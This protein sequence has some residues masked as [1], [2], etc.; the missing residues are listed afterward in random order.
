VL[1]AGC[2]DT[3]GAFD[4]FAA[5]YAETHPSS[6]DAGSDAGA[7]ATPAPDALAGRYLLAVAPAFSLDTPILFFAHFSAES[8]DSD[9]VIGLELRALSAADRQTPVGDV[10]PRREFRVSGGDVR[11]DLGELEITGAADPFIPG[12][13]I[14]TSVV[15]SGRLC[16]SASIDLLCGTAT[17]AVTAPAELNLAGSTWAAVR[18]SEAAP[19]PPI[20]LD[21]ERRAPAPL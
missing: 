20:A 17:G 18:A 15:L 1:A 5:R 7:C 12:A 21:C 6:G 4:D 11:L 9:L 16:S 3:R 19:L 8:A 13:A 10:L 2:V 14:R